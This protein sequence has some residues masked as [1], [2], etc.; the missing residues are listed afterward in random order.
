[1]QLIRRIIFYLFVLIYLILAALIILYSFGYI[2]QPVKKEISQAALSI[3]PVTLPGPI[4]ILGRAA[5]NIKPS[6]CI[7]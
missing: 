4:Y 3:L 7:F 5:L 2:F 6:Q 1:M